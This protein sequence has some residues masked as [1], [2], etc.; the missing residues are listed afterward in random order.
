MF[1]NMVV[2]VYERIIYRCIIIPRLKKNYKYNVSGIKC[3]N[4]TQA[5]SQKIARY[6]NRI[7]LLEDNIP[8]AATEQTPWD[9]FFGQQLW[10]VT[11]IRFER[12]NF[13]PDTHR[14]NEP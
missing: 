8:G 13:F 7:R 6:E 9:V 2:I 14:Y 12:N 5:K 1:T 4:A 11:H 10:R 3:K